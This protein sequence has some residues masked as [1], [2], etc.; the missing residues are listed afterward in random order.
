MCLYLCDMYN[1][2]G[3]QPDNKGIDGSASTYTTNKR[4]GYEKKQ[5]NTKHKK[6]GSA[7]VHGTHAGA[8]MAEI[9]TH[10][11]SIKHK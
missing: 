7:N 2:L 11:H 10:S 3:G 8:Y 6:T 5:E 4:T 1:G 9:Q